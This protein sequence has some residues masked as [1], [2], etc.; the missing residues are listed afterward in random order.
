M[1]SPK[2]SLNDS[3]YADNDYFIAGFNLACKR[4]QAAL[5]E[6]ARKMKR[7]ATA[8]NEEGCYCMQKCK[9]EECPF[10]R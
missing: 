6:E 4:F 5:K 7:L 2:L 3:F 9:V 1:R 10:N 8:C